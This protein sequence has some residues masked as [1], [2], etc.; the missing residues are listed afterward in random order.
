MEMLIFWAVLAVVAVHICSLLETTL[1]SV[2]IA[3]LIDRKSAGSRGAALLLNIKRNN[4]ED[5]IGAVLIVNTVTSTLGTT[6]AGAEATQMFDDVAVGALSVVLMIVLLVVSEIVPKTLATRHSGTLASFA[7]YGLTGLIFIT[8]PALTV[9]RLLIR[10]LARHPSER[11]TRREFAIFVGSAPR[12]GAISLAEAALI[13]NLIYSRNVT[14]GDVMTP[15]SA[16]FMLDQET[17]IAGLLAADGA[18]AFSRIPLFR[19]GREQIVGYISH[20]DVLK[21]AAL[22]NDRTR[23]LAT[24]LRPLPRLSASLDIAKALE[25]LLAEREAIGL[26]ETDRHAPVGLVTLEDLLETL[27][28]MEITDEA[29][30]IESMRPLVTEVR[31]NRTRELQQKRLGQIPP[32]E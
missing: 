28:G 25:H 10:L 1:F 26:V 11:L 2:R 8:R 27:L 23:K 21:A 15:L 6:L 17:T 30:A 24:F 32:P 12:E 3:T 19:D 31:R 16:L 13:G 14:I 4:A 5:A 7:G 18:D 9:T 20:R 22:E 29:D